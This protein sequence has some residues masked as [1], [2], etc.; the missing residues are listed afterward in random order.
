M[1]KKRSTKY[2]NFTHCNHSTKYLSA[3]IRNNNSRNKEL[4]L[5]AGFLSFKNIDHIIVLLSTLS[6][7]FQSFI[8]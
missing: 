5:L 3:A 6:V 1:K 7:M 2:Y 8:G 4:N